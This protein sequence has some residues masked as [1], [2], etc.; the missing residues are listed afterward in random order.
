VGRD[1]EDTSN[2]TIKGHQKTALEQTISHMA[3]G[4]QDEEPRRKN[5]KQG[6]ILQ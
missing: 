5:L 2:K 6:R 1:K 3:S 4:T